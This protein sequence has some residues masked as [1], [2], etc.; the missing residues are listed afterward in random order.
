MLFFYCRFNNEVSDS[1]HV[2]KLNDGLERWFFSVDIVW[3]Q[4]V[5][6]HW[7]QSTGNRERPFITCC[8]T[9]LTSQG[10][11]VPCQ[12]LISSLIRKEDVGV[13]LWTE[14]PFDPKRNTVANDEEIQWSLN[15]TS[16]ET[17]SSD[18]VIHNTSTLPAL[19]L[20]LSL[21]LC[22]YTVYVSQKQTV[23]WWFA[24]NLFLR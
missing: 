9:S 14:T 24:K 19:S 15:Y 17:Y 21:S 11:A 7:V 5:C 16:G 10:K 18:P 2:S 6:V 4:H 22:I 8:N 1:G 23:K 20:S 12:W 13:S 3:E